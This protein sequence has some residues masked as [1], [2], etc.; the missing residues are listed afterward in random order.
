MFILA[1]E[2]SDEL[3]VSSYEELVRKYVVCVLYVVI[4]YCYCYVK[5]VTSSSVHSTVQHR[6][7]LDYLT[8]C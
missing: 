5:T 1:L 6:I 7:I 4:M 2:Q 3:V 8:L